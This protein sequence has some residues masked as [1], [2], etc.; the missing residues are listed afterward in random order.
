MTRRKVK[1][2]DK[3]EPPPL[4]SAAGARAGN[5]IGSQYTRSGFLDGMLKIRDHFVGRSVAHYGS[6][7]NLLERC[8]PRCQNG[9]NCVHTYPKD[10]EA[11]TRRPGYGELSGNTTLDASA[12]QRNIDDVQQKGPGTTY[13]PSTSARDENGSGSAWTTL[14]HS[15]AI[16][17]RAIHVTEGQTYT[18]IVARI[19][20]RVL[21]GLKT[22]QLP[23]GQVGKTI[24]QFIQSL[25]GMAA[26][27]SR[28]AVRL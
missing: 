28:E 16:T 22:S 23:A 6:E 27:T 21:W 19:N 24:H 9:Q 10:K 1:R 11:P 8:N 20:I 15:R 18:A 25:R 17:S 26:R 14:L 2:S 7:F 4:F 5:W 3:I 12:H 13:D